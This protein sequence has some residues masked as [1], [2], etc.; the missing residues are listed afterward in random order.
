MCTSVHGLAALAVLGL[1]PELPGARCAGRSPQWDLELPGETPD[2]QAARLNAAVAA[3]HRCPVLDA[4]AEPARLRRP[5][6]VWHET[7]TDADGAPIAVV[8]HVEPIALGVPVRC[9][10]RLDN[11]RARYGEPPRLDHERDTGGT[12]LHRD[13][14]PEID[15]PLPGAD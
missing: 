1:P 11:E 8:E 13:H 3:C 12:K 9:G 4:C 7:V 5:V 14:D 6:G 2:A 10:R 15:T